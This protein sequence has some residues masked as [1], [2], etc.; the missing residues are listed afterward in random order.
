MGDV[1]EEQDRAAG[2]DAGVD[3]RRARP[4]SRLSARAVDPAAGCL[5]ADRGFRSAKEMAPK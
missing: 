5:V 1:R 2:V 3:G 4:R